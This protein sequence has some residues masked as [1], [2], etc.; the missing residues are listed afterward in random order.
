MLG[1]RVVCPWGDKGAAAIDSDGRV[2]TVPAFPPPGGVVD[3]IGAGD[4]FVAAT[5]SSLSSGLSLEKA[6]TYGSMVAG[7]KVG[8]KGLA[9]YSEAIEQLKE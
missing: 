8:I 2:F 1:A 7:F 4:T 3:T 6:V 9:I 5:I